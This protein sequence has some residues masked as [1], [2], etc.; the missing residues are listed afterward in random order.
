MTHDKI[1]YERYCIVLTHEY[2]D[3]EGEKHSLEEPLAVEYL[4]LDRYRSVLL[5]NEMMDKLKY[6]LLERFQNNA[7]EGE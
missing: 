3:S 4:A 6:A 5:I 1:P 2:V 7:E